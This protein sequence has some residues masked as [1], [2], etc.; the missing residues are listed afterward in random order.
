MYYVTIT[1]A[2]G[3][4]K[5]LTWNADNVEQTINQIN[6]LYRGENI[7]NIQK[8]EPTNWR[9]IEKNRKLVREIA[10]Y[11]ATEYYA[12]CDT[13]ENHAKRLLDFIEKKK[14][15]LNGNTSQG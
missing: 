2:A 15:E 4:V 13:M 8:L 6:D 3:N 14:E 9:T 7:V 10:N 11:L 5:N 12:Q 1:Q